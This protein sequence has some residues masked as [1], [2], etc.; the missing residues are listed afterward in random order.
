MRTIR[1]PNCGYATYN[2]IMNEIMSKVPFAVINA[3]YRPELELANINFWDS[4]YIPP[5]LAHY[6]LNPPAEPKFD[7]SNITLPPIDSHADHT[8]Q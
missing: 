2:A 4:D 7:F 3:D 1:I 8:Y 6:Q 5:A